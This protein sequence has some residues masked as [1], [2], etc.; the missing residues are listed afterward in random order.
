MSFIEPFSTEVAY[1]ASM[2][3]A[4]PPPI[5]LKI[6]TTRGKP[7]FLFVY[8]ER[9]KLTPG[10]QE[11]PVVK[12]IRIR[13]IGQDFKTVSDYTPEDLY[14]LTYRNSHP[15]ADTLSNE[16]NIGAVLL[17]AEDLGDFSFW[18]Q[19]RNLTFELEVD[20]YALIHEDVLE[21]APDTA[22]QLKVLLVYNTHSLSGVSHEARFWDY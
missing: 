19:D 13:H 7:S 8:L 2:R 22:L 3:S 17:T 1:T 16:R 21:D 4:T 15:K 12:H 6:E 20:D 5:S 18:N 14:H 10:I 9:V 11:E